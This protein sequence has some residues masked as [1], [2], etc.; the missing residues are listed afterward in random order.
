MHKLIAI[1]VLLLIGC[2]QEP[3]IARETWEYNKF[4]QSV[5]NGKVEKVS[6]SADRTTAIVKVKF[7]PNLKNVR[8]DKDP[9]LINT[10]TENKV[11][12]S[13]LPSSNR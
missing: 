12:I 11:D 7:D 8:L 13:V 3:I 6:L 10:L 2:V 9:N 5:K 1:I 4:I